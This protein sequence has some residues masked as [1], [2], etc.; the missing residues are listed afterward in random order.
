MRL[1]SIHFEL[2]NGYRWAMTPVNLDQRG[3]EH[4][5]LISVFQNKGLNILDFDVVLDLNSGYGSILNGVGC[6]IGSITIV[7]LET[8]K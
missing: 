7:P 2:T 3:I 8:S 5:I 6:T 4:Q 1:A